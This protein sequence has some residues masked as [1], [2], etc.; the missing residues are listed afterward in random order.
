MLS[1]IM[2]QSRWISVR[3][4]SNSGVYITPEKGNFKEIKRV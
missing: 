3:Q 2:M 1:V 4:R